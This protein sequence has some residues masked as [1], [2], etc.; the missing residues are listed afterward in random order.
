MVRLVIVF[1]VL[2]LIRDVL[3]QGVEVDS[4]ERELAKTR[5]LER[6]VDILNALAFA[7]YDY[8][9]QK[10]FEYSSRAHTLAS[11]ENY[12]DGIAL[13][14]TLNGYY[15]HQVGKFE[16]ARRWYKA[17]SAVDEQKPATRGYN[18]ILT[19]NLLSAQAQY[20][21]AILFLNESFDLVKRGEAPIHLAFAYRSLGK[22]LSLRWQ[23]DKAEEY[24][25]MAMG[26]YEAEGNLFGKATTSFAL[27][28]LDKSKADYGKAEENVLTGCELAGELN[29]SFLQLHCMIL[30]G[31]IQYRLGNYLPALESLLSAVQLL[32]RKEAPALM[33]RVYSDLGDVYDVLGQNEVAL[34]YYFE[35]LK[36]AGMLN[37]PYEI[38]T[39]QGHIAWVYKNQHN[40]KLAFEFVEKS[41]NTRMSIGDEVGVASALNTK[42]IIFFEQKQYDKAEE[43]LNKSLEV[44]NK[45][46]HPEGASITL[47]NLALIFEEQ[48]LYRK[49][50]S[51]QLSNFA[52]E[53]KL[54]NQYNLAGAFNSLGSLYTHLGMYD[55]ARYFLQ[56]GAAIAEE[57]RS[58]R[59][60]MDNA[61][62]WS[63]LFEVRGD[64]K[65]A[66]EWHKRYA[67]LNDSIY[68]ENSANKLAEMN[69]LYHTDQKDQEI[70]LLQQER[71]LQRNE[72][73]LQK[74]K[75]NQQN[76]VII[77]VI[78]A[79]VLVSVVA[80]KWYQYHQRAKKAHEEIM[81]QKE[82]LESQSQ[83][84]KEAYHIIEYINK[85]LEAKV[86]NKSTE[87]EKAYKELDTFFYRAS[88]DFRR[89][90]TTFLGLAEVANI[91]VKDPNALELF[92]KV[93]ETARNLDKM[94]LKLQSISDMGSQLIP[95]AEVNVAAIF[96]EV[97]DIYRDDLGMKRLSTSTSV[98]LSGGFY[99]YPALIQIVVENLFE[100]AINF[101][102]Y[103]NG[104]IKLRALE[105][106]RHVVIEVEDNGEG[107][108]R[109]LSPRIF[110]MYFR[111]SERSKGNGLGLYIVKKA[112]ERLKGILTFDSETGKGTT[113]RISFPS[114]N[115]P[116]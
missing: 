50:L 8:D 58:L 85:K 40:F 103:E 76:L 101:S 41:L 75:I 60:R 43:W 4:L 100:N 14:A 79:F 37:T 77:F 88:H 92:A 70:K 29:D 19:A 93:R 47:Y 57:T 106:D 90:L 81:R 64:T 111:G 56:E 114:G 39:L 84:L 59:L 65:K 80:F 97:L 113:F 7:H 110:D 53:K 61:F 6:Q 49:A 2:F 86:E 31:E 96:Q 17:S 94:L 73:Q 16:R 67:I 44:R 42:G 102:R 33:I 46:N 20:D 11:T 38:A 30:R 36:M 13:A 52:L 63:E 68:D 35:A 91:S 21:S 104:N 87:L 112:A 105:E 115:P 69:A 22:V 9:L 108:S 24:F 5:S 48:K 32:N 28:E 99:S 74:T 107:I 62:F 71:M 26:I 72:L 1:F 83:E 25:R 27:S 18:L 23:N 15:Y 109:D 66:L 95:Y 55:S 98:V 116:A 51:Y 45:I 89:P 10:G 3:G 82:E 12:P 54:G 34:R 78:V